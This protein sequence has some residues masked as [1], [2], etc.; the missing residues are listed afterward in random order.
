MELGEDV[1][2]KTF[3]RG[4][5]SGNNNGGGTNND[6]DERTNDANVNVDEDDWLR[7]PF[8][9]NISALVALWTYGVVMW[10]MLCLLRVLLSFIPFISHF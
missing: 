1:D 2:L 6:I 5:T 4:S 7:Q 9:N 10:T 3:G 8:Y